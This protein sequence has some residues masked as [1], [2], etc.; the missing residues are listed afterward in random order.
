MH[1][2]IAR[3]R[4]SSLFALKL[5]EATSTGAKSL[6]VPMPYAIRMALLDA[7][8]RTEGKSA[9]SEAFEL[10]KSLRLA[11][12]PCE[13]AAVSGIFLRILKPRREEPKTEPEAEDGQTTPPERDGFWTRTIA[14]REYV[15]LAGEL[16]LAFGGHPESLAKIRPWLGQINTFGKRGSFFQLQEQPQLIE[17]PEEE[18]PQGFWPFPGADLRRQ[19]PKDRF[20]LGI[21]QRVDEWGAELTFDQANSYM[22]ES[23][24][25]VAAGRQRVDVIL[26]YQLAYAGRGLTF[27]RRFET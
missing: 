16:G 8:I 14:F 9:A 2:L 7:A 1:W 5:V 4:S 11:I 6:L 21:V 19:A 17:R 10:I 12:R 24:P 3:Y 27:Y 20:P 15:H 25:R 13:Y 18:V 26:P 23:V 22:A